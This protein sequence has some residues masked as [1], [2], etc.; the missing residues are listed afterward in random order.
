[1]KVTEKE[2]KIEKEKY[3]EKISVC[4]SERDREE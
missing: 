3:R 4:K 1:M 2:V